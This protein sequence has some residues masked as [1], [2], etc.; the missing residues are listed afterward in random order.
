MFKHLTTEI[1]KFSFHQIQDE[2]EWSDFVFNECVGNL[3]SS[4][5]WGEYKS[6]IGWD[7]IRVFVKGNG[8]N[9]I[10]AALQVQVKK[11]G[12]VKIILVQG[13]VHLSNVSENHCVDLFNELHNKYLNLGWSDVLLIN[14]YESVSDLHVRS[15]MRLGYQPYINNKMYSFYI[16]FSESDFEDGFSKNWRHNL[17]RAR[18]NEALVVRWCESVNDRIEAFT[19]LEGMYE[20]LTVRKSFSSA[21]DTSKIKDMIVYDKNFLIAVAEDNGV[22]VAVRVAYRTSKCVTDFLAASNHLAKK[23]YA[24]YLI[25][26][27]L[28]KKSE[29]L[30]VEGFECGGIDPFGNTG[31]YNFKRGLGASLSING[32]FWIYHTNNKIKNLLIS[33]F[34]IFS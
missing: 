20:K 30:D 1:S 8:S 6:R 11:K 29:D 26:W 16:F 21:I 2:L 22:P 3:Y 24:N 15:M 34:S 18:K 25:L 33:I 5:V 10:I 17:K 32:P 7:V 28:I 12:P 4:W 13:G 14:Y 9:E 31:V 23:N 19:T 27:S